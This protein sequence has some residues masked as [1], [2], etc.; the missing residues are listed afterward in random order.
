MGFKI[1]LGQAHEYI[2]H[3]SRN[4]AKPEHMHLMLCVLQNGVATCSVWYWVVNCAQ[5]CCVSTMFKLQL[6]DHQ[7]HQGPC[8][9]RFCISL[10]QIAVY[11]AK[12]YYIHNIFRFRV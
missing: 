10:S 3:D 12:Q 2:M 1:V 11:L 8:S 6:S 4:Y 5:V 9:L 7:F